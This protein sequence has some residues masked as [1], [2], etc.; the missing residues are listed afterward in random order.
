MALFSEAEQEMVRLAIEAAELKTSGEIRVCAEK[1]CKNEPIERATNYFTKL[2]MEKTAERNGVLIYIATDDKKF[3]IIGDEGI[4][5]VVDADFWDCTKE[6]ML[7]KFR[8][9]K[10]AEGITTGIHRAG[11]RMGE[12]FPSRGNDK[13][14]LSNDI[15]FM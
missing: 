8:E 2:G 9:G 14:E 1:H 5:S 13:N 6:A 4:N 3:A 12:F 15:A 11:E 10:I 7:E